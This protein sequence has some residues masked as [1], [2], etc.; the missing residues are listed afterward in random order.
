MHS[1]FVGGKRVEGLVM[2]KKGPCIVEG[3][4]N[5]AHAKGYCRRHYG[6]IWRKGMIYDSPPKDRRD[7]EAHLRGDHHERLRAL[8][9][10]LK[11]SL[12]MYEIVVGFQ[13]R[14]KWR[15][16]IESVEEE[17]RKIREAQGAMDT[18]EPLVSVKTSRAS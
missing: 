3:C 17:I 15:R 12:Q 18:V 16:E 6:Q 7:E 2:P 1:R 8:E 4:E 14:I 10:E 13:G 9:R 5:P 11:K